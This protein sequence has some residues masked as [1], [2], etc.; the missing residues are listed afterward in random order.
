MLGKRKGDHYVGGYGFQFT[1]RSSAEVRFSV[2]VEDADRAF[3]YLAKCAQA[4]GGYALPVDDEAGQTSGDDWESILGTIASVAKRPEAKAAAAVIPY[5][6]LIR[7]A[8][9]GAP[10]AIRAVQGMTGGGKAP[11]SKM[12][13]TVARAAQGDPE[14]V[15]YYQEVTRRDGSSETASRLAAQAKLAAINLTVLQIKAEKA[16]LADLEAKLRE[17]MRPIAEKIGEGWRKRQAAAGGAVPVETSRVTNAE[18]Y[19]S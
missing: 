8:A 1:P 10:D 13:Q 19:G 17:Q 4:L 9:A 6:E 14:A 15:A 3:R 7:G 5:G 11:P 2:H 16:K 12:V 18:G